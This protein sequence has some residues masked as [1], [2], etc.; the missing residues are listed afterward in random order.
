MGPAR[1]VPA[2]PTALEAYLAEQS[3]RVVAGAVLAVDV[4]EGSEAEARRVVGSKL[5]LQIAI[6]N[7]LCGLPLESR[8][9]NA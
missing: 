6:N 7:A 3:D 9:I 8:S 5:L 1:S 4:R 2:K